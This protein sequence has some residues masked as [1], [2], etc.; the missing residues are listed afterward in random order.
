MDRKLLGLDDILCLTFLGGLLAVAACAVLLFNRGQG[1]SEVTRADAP[2]VFVSHSSGISRNEVA[3][4]EVLSPE[5]PPAESASLAPD[6][7]TEPATFTSDPV[8]AFVKQ[9]PN[10]PLRFV[11]KDATAMQ[12]AYL[13]SEVEIVLQDWQKRR[14]VLFEQANNDLLALIPGF[15]D[16][17]SLA[18]PT[19]L[20]QSVID[21]DQDRQSRLKNLML[22]LW[23]DCGLKP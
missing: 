12:M 5:E 16:D 21:N 11:P 4:S 18:Q 8:K 3:T 19:P 10:T 17:G 6:E 14:T 15:N 13:Q 20:Q 23:P 2:P 22:S 1:P 7:A 9:N